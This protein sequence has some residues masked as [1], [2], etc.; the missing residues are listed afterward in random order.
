MASAE[1]ILTPIST[2]LLYKH[3]LIRMLNNTKFTVTCLNRKCSG[4]ETIKCLHA[5]LKKESIIVGLSW[6]IH[7]LLSHFDSDISKLFTEECRI[8]SVLTPFPQCTSL[9]FGFHSAG[10][11]CALS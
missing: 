6:G 5:A 7:W 1:S 4:H 10:H 9:D 11:R 2:A 8:I 3:I